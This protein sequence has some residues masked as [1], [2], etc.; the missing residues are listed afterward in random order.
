MQRLFDAGGILIGKTNMDQ[1]GIGLVGVRS[2]YGICSSVFDEAYI[3]GG[4]SSGSAVVVAAGL[5]SFALGNDAA[6]SGRVPAAFNNIVG[7][8]PTPGLISNSAVS[9]GGTVKLI[10]T[11]SVL[12]LTCADTLA[13]LELIAGTAYAHGSGCES[14]PPDVEVEVRAGERV[15]CCLYVPADGATT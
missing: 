15:E 5:V 12:G 9:G 3:S 10:E 7:L 11:I 4:S 13:V 14:L 8:K 2:P 1:F 6:G